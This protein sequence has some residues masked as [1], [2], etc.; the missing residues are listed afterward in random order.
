MFLDLLRIPPSV[1]IFLR[2]KLEYFLTFGYLK[3]LLMSPWKLW[4]WSCVSSRLKHM[5]SWAAPS[6]AICWKCNSEYLIPL[7]FQF[8][9]PSDVGGQF[10]SVMIFTVFLCFGAHRLEVFIQPL[11]EKIVLDIQLLLTG[12]V[13]GVDAQIWNGSG[14]CSDKCCQ[15]AVLVLSNGGATYRHTACVGR[16]CWCWFSVCLLGTCRRTARDEPVTSRRTRLHI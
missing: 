5:F 4:P 14:T 1:V 6:M 11:F 2:A 10:Y 8:L 7:S 16:R 9:G 12:Y 13:H 15:P 3:H